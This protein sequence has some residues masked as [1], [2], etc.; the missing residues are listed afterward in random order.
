MLN[1]LSS[2]TANDKF[3]FKVT[4]HIVNIIQIIP[5]HKVVISKQLFNSFNW[6]F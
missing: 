4:I 6:S 1:P 5:V 3:K 2:S